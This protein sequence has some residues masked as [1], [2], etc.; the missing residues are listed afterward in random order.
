MKETK[1]LYGVIEEHPAVSF[2]MDDFQCVFINTAVD[3]KEPECLSLHHGYIV[4]RT[5]EGRYIYIYSHCD[6]H[7]HRKATLNTW[8]YIVSSRPALEQFEGV[9]F[10]SGILNK[11]F[12]KSALEFDYD[13]SSY[14][15]V[16]YKDDKEIYSL[17]NDKI[18]GMLSISSMVC[19]SMSVEKGDSLATTGTELSLAFDEPKDIQIFPQIYGYVMNLCQF[20]A[21]RKNIGFET[22]VL[23]EK[24]DMYP[25]MYNEKAQCYVRSEYASF[26][27][28]SIVSCLTFNILGRCV[29]GLLSSIVDNKPKKPQFN[30]GYIPENDKDVNI[31][32]GIKIREL[33]SALESE[34]ELA[35]ITVDQEAEFEKLLQ[36]L[37]DIVKA[38]R[39]GENPITDPKA[40]DYILGSLGHLTGALADRIEKCFIMYQPLMGEWVSRRQID[41]LVRY[42]NTIT[43]GSFMQL[44]GELAETT[45]VL[46]KLVYCCVLKRI[47]MQDEQIKDVMQRRLIS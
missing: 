24:N 6:I 45:Y 42:R 30:L 9:S 47:G 38:H 41:E 18:K 39:D 20:M 17:T 1:K 10:R 32:T 12:Y 7:V 25:G 14:K 35:K 36:Q 34:M 11:L 15:K 5:T 29:D 13:D 4:G 43:H 40:Y 26:T 28:K 37:R 16:K 22:I 2:V 31:V 21:F 23:E 3:K 44:N 8:L 33:C 19:E 27:A 46:M